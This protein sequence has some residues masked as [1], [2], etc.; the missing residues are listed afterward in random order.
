M[1]RLVQQVEARERA[2]PPVRPRAVCCAWAKHAG[3]RETSAVRVAADVLLSKA[4]A[5]ASICMLL[6]R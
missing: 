6:Q 2:G 4:G 1:R 3:W 5:A